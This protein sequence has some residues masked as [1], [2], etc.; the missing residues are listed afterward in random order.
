[1]KKRNRSKQRKRR[2]GRRKGVESSVRLPSALSR[3]LSPGLQRFDAFD[4]D[5][6]DS[7][8]LGQ[9]V[10]Q[11]SAFFQRGLVQL[12]LAHEVL[13]EAAALAAHE[14]EFKRNFSRIVQWKGNWLFAWVHWAETL[15]QL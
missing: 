8:C 12:P 4:C 13:G 7:L 15:L 1:M 3:V 9:C 5:L 6:Q 11:L 10:V 2:D 14:V